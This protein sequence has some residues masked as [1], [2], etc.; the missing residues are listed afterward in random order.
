MLNESPYDRHCRLVKAVTAGGVGP[1]QAWTEL[2]E[3][4]TAFLSDKGDAAERLTQAVI[5]GDTDAI[6][7]LRP[8]ALAE[9]ITEG[10]PQTAARVNNAVRSAIFE[11]LRT[12]YAQQAEATYSAL[13][14]QFDTVA[15][16]FT[17]AADLVDP[18]AEA[19]AILTAP[20]KTRNAW[21]E[22]PVLAARL[23]E[24]VPA[25]HAAATLCGTVTAK[26]P[27]ALLLPLT[28]DV[29]GQHR[30]HI[31]AAVNSTGRA[32]RWGTIV[33]LGAT[34]RAHRDPASVEPYRQPRPFETRTQT[35]AGETRVYQVDPEDH[36]YQ[37]PAQP[38]SY[39]G[40]VS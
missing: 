29:T 10:Q 37:A 15:K 5:A 35:T 17:A 9:A 13:A 20:A 32:G 30:R 27:D 2:Y 22:A 28:V 1:P 11:Q 33:A 25:L 7:S 19:E 18:G 8:L 38:F 12:L 39:A 31:W 4:F 40:Q 14:D 23:D 16:K 3:R 26:G 6:A 34:I 21:T 36:D 24:L